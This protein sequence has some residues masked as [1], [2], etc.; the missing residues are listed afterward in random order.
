MAITTFGV[1]LLLPQFFTSAAGRVTHGV[2]LAAGCVLPAAVLWRAAGGQT[3][4][5][6]T[7]T[8]NSRSANRAIA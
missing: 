6:V 3:R 7:L 8:G 4:S 5:T 1:G 2:L